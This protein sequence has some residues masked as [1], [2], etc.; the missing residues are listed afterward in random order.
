MSRWTS[1]ATVRVLSTKH[2]PL[3]PRLRPRYKLHREHNSYIPRTLLVRTNNSRQQSRSFGASLCWHGPA[4]FSEAHLHAPAMK[5]HRYM[6]T[7]L[8]A[9]AFLLA[10]GCTNGP[11]ANGSFDR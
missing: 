2:S 6:A 4:F 9:C 7:A 1:K 5:L 10:V 8:A 11:A 3:P